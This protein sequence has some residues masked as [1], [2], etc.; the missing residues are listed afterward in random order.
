MA[1]RTFTTVYAEQDGWIVGTVEELPGAIVQER[2][3]EEARE[4]MQEV[5]TTLLEVNRDV[6]AREF[7]TAPLVREELTVLV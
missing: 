1:Q 2:T 3:M 4:S 5:I 6:R 7:G